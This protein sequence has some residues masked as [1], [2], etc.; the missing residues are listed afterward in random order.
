MTRRT[1]SNG[2]LR[3]AFMTRL[4]DNARR[5]VQPDTGAIGVFMRVTLAVVFM[6]LVLVSYV[7]LGAV[8]V[9]FVGVLALLAYF[10]PHLY[11][12]LA[13]RLVRR[14]TRRTRPAVQ[15]RPLQES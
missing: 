6:Y 5:S 10:I 4:L 12:I 9:V 13:A 11:G 8:G 1:D 15:Q 2:E 7:M 14:R 3:A